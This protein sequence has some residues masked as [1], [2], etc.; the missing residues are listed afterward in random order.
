MPNKYYAPGEQRSAKVG[1]LFARIAPR[2]DLINDLQSFGL[3]RWWKHRLVR[4]ADVQPGQRALD[5]CCGTGDVAFSLAR[6]GAEVVGLDF[7]EPMLAVARERLKI[8]SRK[9]PAGAEVELV[10]GDAQQLPF[11]DVSFDVV[12]MC[13]GLRNLADWQRGL[14]EMWRAAKPRGRV[15]VLDFGQP[16]NTTLRKL[17]FAYLGLVVPLFGKVFC[18]DAAAY[19]YILESLKVYPAQEGVA[20]KMRQMQFTEVQVHNL[21]GG[22]MSINRARRA[23]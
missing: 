9:F 1:D 3:H 11:R 19:A 12:T 17:Y 23:K 14:S 10:K 22:M 6:Q 7:S 15:L 4:L 21:L 5:L 2:Y 18:G 20:G 13:Y 8:E 16:P